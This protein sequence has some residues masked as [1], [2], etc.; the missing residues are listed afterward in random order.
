[1]LE[2]EKG[3]NGILYD[4]PWSPELHRTVRNV[5]IWRIILTQ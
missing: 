2:V 4:S 5:T 3:P 1:M